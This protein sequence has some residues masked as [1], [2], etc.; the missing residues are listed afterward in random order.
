MSNLQAQGNDK[1]REPIHYDFMS[2]SEVW[3]LHFILYIIDIIVMLL[4]IFISISFYIYCHI[5]FVISYIPKP[6]ACGPSHSNCSGCSSGTLNLS[7]YA[8]PWEIHRS[9]RDVRAPCRVRGSSWAM[10]AARAALFL[11]HQCILLC[12]G[13]VLIHLLSHPCG[14]ARR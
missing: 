1:T 6:A 2:L 8:L 7:L 5:A 13:F 3:P 11:F 10:A 14:A 4:Y 12:F 9:K